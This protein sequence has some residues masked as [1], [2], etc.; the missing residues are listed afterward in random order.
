VWLAEDGRTGFAVGAFDLLVR[1]DDGGASWRRWPGRTDNPKGLHL[2]AIARAAGELWIAGEQG[3]LL[4]L[5][6][7]GERFRSVRV[8]YGGSFFGVTGDERTVLV[9]GLRGNAF[10]S[11]DLGAT[12]ERVDTG[13]DESLHGAAVAPDG[14]LVLVA[15]GG[16]VLASE[17]GGRCFRAVARARIAPASAVAATANAAG[18]AVAVVGAGGVRVEMLR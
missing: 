12:W 7:D 16:R 18:I 10:R 13:V 6:R 8:P 9:F 1:T 4:R 3:L 15:Q 17:D 5:D 14:R 11:S 2:H